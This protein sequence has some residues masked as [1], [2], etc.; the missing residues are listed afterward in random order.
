[1]AGAP[2]ALGPLRQPRCASQDR[3]APR[4][5]DKRSAD[6]FDRRGTAGSARFRDGRAGQSR[7]WP[8]SGTPRQCRVLRRLGRSGRGLPG[9]RAV[10]RR[11]ADCAL[12]HQRRRN[13]HLSRRRQGPKRDTARNRGHDVS[14]SARPKGA[15]RHRARQTDLP[16][17]SPRDWDY[18]P[19]HPRRGCASP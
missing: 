14:R 17:R 11:S 12:W 1:M 10:S 9:L 6:E 8:D 7:V 4:G 15:R 3:A 18:W 19:A 5:R 13:A 2:G 16:A